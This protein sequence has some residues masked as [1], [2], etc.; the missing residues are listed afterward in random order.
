MLL[1]EYGYIITLF[2]FRAASI[3]YLVALSTSIPQKPEKAQ[4]KKFRQL[5]QPSGGNTILGW[6]FD[7][8]DFRLP[9]WPNLPMAWHTCQ[10][11]QIL[12][13]PLAP[14]HSG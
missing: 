7:K 6:T 1:A 4:P 2:E 10:P 5:T 12:N 8:M 13:L 14:S 3:F 9:L 11:H